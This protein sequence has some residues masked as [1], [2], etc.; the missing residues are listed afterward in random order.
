MGSAFKGLGAGFAEGLI[1][2]TFH[3]LSG[4]FVGLLATSIVQ[5][6][7]CTTSI[8]VALVASGALPLSQAIPV[9]MGANIGTTVTNTIVSMAHITRGSEFKRAISA[10]IIH[11]LFNIF[12]V[13]LIFPIELAFHVLEKGSLLL[14]RLF[15]G[16]GGFTLM[17]PLKIAVSPV[18]SKI[19]ELLH[20]P[21]I[22]LIVALILLF[23]SLRYIVNIMKRLTLTRF[24]VFLHH[25][26]FGNWFRSIMLG[27]VITAV[28]QSSSVTTSL[29]V[30][31][32]AS[33]LLSLDQVF[34]FTLGANLGTTVTAML[35]SL[36]TQNS[37]A[38]ATAFSH[39]LF[40]I[41]GIAIIFPWK[42]G[43]AVPL[44]LARKIGALA[45]QHKKCAIVI[46]VLVFYILPL[47]FILL[48]RLLFRR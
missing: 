16:I 41:L 35:A 34:P 33:G 48:E 31:L 15:T 45:T 20:F 18:A 23:L 24:G 42:I 4:L 13:I 28:I 46:L 39:F 3:P 37:I 29:M 26:A 47:G 17:S 40:N 30:P 9:I 22:T 1:T 27:L 32:A 14:T 2:G 8:V 10:A 12:A 6:S 11:D 43:R 25:Y 19:A 38:I 36:V 7:S 21:P 5:S 44:S